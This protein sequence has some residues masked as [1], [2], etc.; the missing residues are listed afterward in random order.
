MSISA[1]PTLDPVAALRFK[2][3]QSTSSPAWLHDEV[4]RRMQER[5]DWFKEEPQS[6]IDWEPVNGGLSTCRDL[7][8][9]YP[10]ATTLVVEHNERRLLEVKK[11]LGFI[12]FGQLFQYLLG[13]VPALKHSKLSKRGRRNFS[14]LPL[15]KPSQVDLVWANMLLHL[16]P[17]PTELIRSWHESLK[18]G[19]W[20]MFTCLG[21]DTSKQLRTIYQ[22]KGWTT[23]SHEFTDMHDWGDMLVEAGFADPVMDMERIT[24][25]YSSP[26]ALIKDLRALGRNFNHERFKGLRGKR[27]L[28]DFKSQLIKLSHPADSNLKGQEALNKPL[29]IPLTFEIIYGHAF[30]VA[31]KIKVTESSSFSAEDMRAML[32]TK[33]T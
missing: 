11:E 22:D 27:W 14:L 25:T 18:V 31:P 8:K 33:R 16:V 23:P 1:P 12:G 15:N 7:Q 21:P 4:A 5:L 19:G 24:L 10:S 2:A 28:E 17:N 9:R 3:Q 20:V 30:K 29:A 13:F 32:K 6:W 26:D